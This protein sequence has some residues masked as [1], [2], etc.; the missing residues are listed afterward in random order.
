VQGKRNVGKDVLKDADELLKLNVPNGVV[1]EF[2]KIKSGHS[3]SEES[4]KKMKQTVVVNE[5]GVKESSADKLLRMLKED[6]KIEYIAYFGSLSEAEQTVR[7]RKKSRTTN[8]AK[9]KRRKKLNKKDKRSIARAEAAKLVKATEKDK[10][11]TKTSDV[12]DAMDIEK[13]TSDIP[14]I[15]KTNSKE[16]AVA[17]E[18]EEEVTDVSNE[19]KSFIKSVIGGY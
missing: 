16:D 7:I 8:S 4:I 18:T 19:A 6:D 12:N 15:D 2:I 13:E 9:T 3:L 17:K 11:N 5:H 1:R 10:S 14:N